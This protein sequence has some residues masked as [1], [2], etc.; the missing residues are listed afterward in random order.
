MPDAQKLIIGIVCAVKSNLKVVIAAGDGPLIK[1]GKPN[2]AGVFSIQTFF[3]YRKEKKSY[4]LR[5]KVDKC[6][7]YGFEICILWSLS[8]YKNELL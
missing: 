2:T 5:I 8:L 1:G 3:N 7:R 6:L 4:Y